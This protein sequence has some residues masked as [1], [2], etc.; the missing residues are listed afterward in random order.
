M[1]SKRIRSPATAAFCGWWGLPPLTWWWASLFSA[2]ANAVHEVEVRSVATQS[3]TRQRVRAA[4]A[5]TWR[6]PRSSR[7][8]R[9]TRALRRSGT[10]IEALAPGIL[11]AAVIVGA[12]WA[13]ALASWSLVVS[14]ETYRVGDLAP[15]VTAI[16]GLLVLTLLASA[17]TAEIRWRRISTA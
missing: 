1:E 11:L 5:S 16:G 14:G 2:L 12:V 7:C 3:M 4:D 17:G 15:G 13:G 9:G 6:G 8:S 10:W